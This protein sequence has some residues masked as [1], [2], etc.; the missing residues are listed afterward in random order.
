MSRQR[1]RS[2]GFTLI[3]VLVALTILG[4]ALGVLLSVF[5][6]SLARAGASQSEATAAQ[7]AQSLLADAG[8]DAA[9]ADGEQTGTLA[10]GMRWR[11]QVAPYGD[12]DDSKAW[13]IAAKR[14]TA[15][16]SWTDG[17]AERSV[18]LTTLRL[19]P[20]APAP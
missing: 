10:S 4:I 2:D 19:L 3:E 17:G 6:T 8:N 18:A 7:L 14:V 13:P 5:S 16:V 20:K 1:P 15:M 11:L 9:L 12:N